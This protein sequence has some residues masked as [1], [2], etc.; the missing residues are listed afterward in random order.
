MP[1]PWATSDP[2]KDRIA[3]FINLAGGRAALKPWWDELV[4]RA[5]N[6]AYADLLAGLVGRGYTVA[7][8][9][10]WDA[11][12]SISVELAAYYA[13]LD[14]Q[15]DT[16]VDDAKLARLDPRQRIWGDRDRKLPPLMLTAGGAMLLP[17]S[18]VGSGRLATTN[19]PFVHDEGHTT[20]RVNPWDAGY[21]GRRWQG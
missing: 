12:A 13:I 19:D 17:T 20:G 11:R 5:I 9:D 15:W 4:D 14:G 18:A 1:G 6:R 10:T 16:D 7:Q 2:V 8:L 3:A 21:P